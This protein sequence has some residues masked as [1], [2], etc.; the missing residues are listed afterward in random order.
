MCVDSVSK[1]IEKYR[2]VLFTHSLTFLSFF[3]KHFKLY[4]Q[5]YYACY[6]K[7]FNIHFLVIGLQ[8]LI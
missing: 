6:L 3:Y 4:N 7:I 1:S 2:D 8:N 5:L